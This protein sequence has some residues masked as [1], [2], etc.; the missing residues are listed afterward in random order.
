MKFLYALIYAYAFTLYSL[1]SYSA[2]ASH[3]TEVLHEAVNYYNASAGGIATEKTYPH[4]MR[5]V[6]YPE[7][8]K[9]YRQT[10]EAIGATAV[11]FPNIH[12]IPKQATFLSTG[13]FKCTQNDIPFLHTSGVHDCITLVAFDEQTKKS[14]LYHVSKMELRPNH[15]GEQTFET[16]FIPEFFR[17]FGSIKPKITLIGS[18]YSNDVS[19]LIGFL[20]KH[21]LRVLHYDFPDIVLKDTLTKDPATKLIHEGT[22]TLFLDKTSV[23][24]NEVMFPGTTDLKIPSTAVLLDTHNGSI[25]VS[26]D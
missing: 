6:H 1:Y 14:C 21:G 12:D 9:E 19:L 16:Y 10:I 18:T 11:H 15:F 25:K 8:I 3:Q 7:K 4:T 5:V 22:T 23:Q 26:R 17:F 13:E 20:K 24:L 2:I